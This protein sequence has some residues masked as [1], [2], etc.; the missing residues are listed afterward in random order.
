MTTAID[1]PVRTWAGGLHHKKLGLVSGDINQALRDCGVADVIILHPKNA[2]LAGEVPDGVEVRYCTGCLGW[3][4]MLGQRCMGN[5]GVEVG[6]GIAEYPP[7]NL[8]PINEKKITVDKIQP[9]EIEQKAKSSRGSKV[10]DLP[11]D[12]IGELSRQG[13]GAKAIA[14]RLREEGVAVSYKTVQ[15]RLQGVLV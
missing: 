13:Y 9:R 5:K 11:G 14:S 6:K 4:V 2:F 1:I 7:T 15:R 10:K 12:R 8:S 3:E